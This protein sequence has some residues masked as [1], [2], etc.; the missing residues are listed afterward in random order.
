MILD[1]VLVFSLVVMVLT[2]FAVFYI[3]KD[4]NDDDD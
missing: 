3:A 1:G 2:L 4:K